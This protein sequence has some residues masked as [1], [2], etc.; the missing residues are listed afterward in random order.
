MEL[1]EGDLSHRFI[2]KAAKV[3]KSSIA[4]MLIQSFSFA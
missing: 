1:P 4:T 2:K 3:E